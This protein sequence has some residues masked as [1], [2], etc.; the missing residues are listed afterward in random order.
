[1]SGVNVGQGE[2]VRYCRPEPTTFYREQTTGLGAAVFTNIPDRGL[3]TVITIGLSDHV[4][5][6]SKSGRGVRQELLVCVR[7][8]FVFLPWHEILFGV[9]ARLMRS[10]AALLRGDV[11]GPAGLLFPESKECH[12]TALLA[13]VPAFFDGGFLEIVST[14]P[15]SVMVELLPITTEEAE[16]I[17]KCGWWE[18]CA[19]IDNGDVDILD[20]R[21]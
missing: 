15:V 2:D 1:M 5:T 10:G 12:S 11:I 7:S 18:F 8:E 4:L 3:T 21:R 16:S 17:D 9:A 20:L 14:E 19:K 13:S 6:Q